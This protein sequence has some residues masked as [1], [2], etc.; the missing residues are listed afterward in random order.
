MVES[1]KRSATTT[2]PL[3][4]WGRITSLSTCAR[5][6]VTRLASAQAAISAWSWPRKIPRTASPRVVPPGSRTA[7]TGRPAVS[8]AATRRAAW[9][10]LPEPSQ[11]SRLTRKPRTSVRQIPGRD[12]V[13]VVGPGFEV[14]E[15]RQ[16]VADLDRGVGSQHLHRG[17][18]GL[19]MLDR[20]VA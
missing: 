17:A 11:P 16:G 13:V 15:P 8:S 19:G 5:A 9:V 3:A 6:A 1:A 18:A 14:V 2:V 20:G 12:L 10:V 7:T 4:I